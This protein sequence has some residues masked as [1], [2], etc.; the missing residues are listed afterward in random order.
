MVHPTPTLLFRPVPALMKFK[1]HHPLP[2]TPRDSTAL[3]NLLTSS[4]RKNLNAEHP[5]SEEEHHIRISAKDAK[6]TPRQSGT[7]IHLQS[8]L[9]NPLFSSASKRPEKTH[10][11][12]I[13]YQAMETFERAVGKGMMDIRYAT[14]CLLATKKQIVASSVL[15]IRDSMKASGAGL[16]VLNWINAGGADNGLGFLRDHRFSEIFFEFLVAEGLQEAAWKWIK[17]YLDLLPASYFLKSRDLSHLRKTISLPLSHLVQAEM[18]GNSSLDAVYL[19]M[20]RAAAYCKGMSAQDIRPILGGPGYHVLKETL[21]QDFKRPSPTDTHFESFTS[22]LPTILSS[23]TALTAH[24]QL[25]HPTK[26]SAD[27]AIDFLRT[28]YFEEE[29]DMT[30]WQRQ[31]VIELGLATARFLMKHQDQPANQEDVHW[32]LEMLQA[33]FQKELGEDKKAQQ[34]EKVKAEAT[35]LDLLARLGFS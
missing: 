7:D 29:H 3:L 8:V 15:N 6:A 12:H 5:I 11:D 4:F 20:S 28:L 30:A 31:R 16:Q 19:C 32:I 22:L 21:R 26:P 25:I 24:L 18:L 34:L 10:N 35:S 2:L 27:L 33:R 14:V 1:I 23:H 17:T 13:R 9:S